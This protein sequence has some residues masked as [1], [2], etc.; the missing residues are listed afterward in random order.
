MISVQRDSATFILYSPASVLS[1]KCPFV[2]KILT[3]C[4]RE[5]CSHDATGDLTRTFFVTKGYEKLLIR[6][7]DTVDA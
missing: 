4:L 3:F 2:G 6:Q 7:Y 5:L 1:E